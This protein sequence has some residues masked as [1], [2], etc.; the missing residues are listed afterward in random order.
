MNLESNPLAMK[1]GDAVNHRKD[2]HHTNDTGGAKLSD[3]VERFLRDANKAPPW[4]SSGIIWA[5]MC[6]RLNDALVAYKK[7]VD[8]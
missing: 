8:K 7:A 2:K 1:S 3:A 4:E 5:E 6:G